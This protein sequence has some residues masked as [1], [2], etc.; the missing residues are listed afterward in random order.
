MKM[1]DVHPQ[2]RGKYLKNNFQVSRT[3][4][5][6][7]QT[8]AVDSPQ[9]D[10]PHSVTNPFEVSMFSKEGNPNQLMRLNIS[11]S[12]FDDCKNYQGKNFFFK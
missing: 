8:V 11:A 12:D 5:L 2:Q 7:S 1:D 10:S 4:A 6:L 3:D 9:F